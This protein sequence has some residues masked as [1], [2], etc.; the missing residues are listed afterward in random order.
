MLAKGSIIT[1][2]D[3]FVSSSPKRLMKTPIRY[4][5]LSILLA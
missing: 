4:Y 2:T 5:S 3:F 1:I